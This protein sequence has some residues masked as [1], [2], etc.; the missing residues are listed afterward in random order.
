MRSYSSPRKLSTEQELYASALRALMR[1]AHSIHEMRQYLGRRA[2]TKNHI[3]RVIAR[4]REQSYLDDARYALDYTHQHANSRRQGRFRIA[5][6]LRARGVPDHHIDAALEAVF[7]DTDEAS[8]VRARLQR[9][10]AHLR[11]PLDQRKLASLHRSLLRA[12]FSSDVIRAELRLAARAHE[13]ALPAF[14][15]PDP[16]DDPSSDE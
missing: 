14:A 3:D 4:L 9:H 2:E 16:P 7:A 6:E 15:F 5:R 10:L 1:R 12:G 13:T 8:S 11:G